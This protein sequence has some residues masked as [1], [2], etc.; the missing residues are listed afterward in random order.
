MEIPLFLERRAPVP[1]AGQPPIDAAP[2]VV[3]VVRAAPVERVPEKVTEDLEV[4]RVERAVFRV[5][6]CA[7]RGRLVQRRQLGERVADGQEDTID[8]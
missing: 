1:R 8:L 2:R 4:E 3:K 7:Q 5:D 6:V